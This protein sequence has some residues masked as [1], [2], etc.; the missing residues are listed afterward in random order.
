MLWKTSGSGKKGTGQNKI[1]KKA[2]NTIN[3]RYCE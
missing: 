2:Q 3:A 1:R